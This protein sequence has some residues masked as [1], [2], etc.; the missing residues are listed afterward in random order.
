[1]T[2]PHKLNKY[3]KDTNR[4]Q[5]REGTLPPGDSKGQGRR[6]AYKVGGESPIKLPLGQDAALPGGAGEANLQGEERA[7]R[8]DPVPV[9]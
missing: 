3:P 5:H 9:A 1:M 6:G 2:R 4:S 7:I 8:A